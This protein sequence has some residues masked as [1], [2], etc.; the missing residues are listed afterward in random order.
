MTDATPTRA[1]KFAAVVAPAAERAGF[2]GHGARARLARAT[3]MTESSI[4]RMLLGQSIPDPRFFQPLADAL[5][6]PVRTLLVEAEII[7]E[8]ALTET[9]QSQVRSQIT[10][11]TAA[12]EFGIT[13]P[14]DR[15]LLLGL[16]ARLRRNHNSAPTSGDSTAGGTAAGQ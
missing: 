2:T 13:D 7:S 9:S 3:G 12:D 16:I 15:Q 10:P 6:L 8:R 14:E 5:E 11:E 4:S 1:E